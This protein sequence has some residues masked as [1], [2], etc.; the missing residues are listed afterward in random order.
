MCTCTHLDVHS[1]VKVHVHV[2]NHAHSHVKVHVHVW[3]YSILLRNHKLIN[4]KHHFQIDMSL[5]SWVKLEI[6]FCD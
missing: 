1:H 6:K 4:Y 2:H 3:V 5:M